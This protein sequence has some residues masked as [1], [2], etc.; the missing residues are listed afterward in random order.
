[1]RVQARQD[2]WLILYAIEASARRL[3]QF[4]PDFYGAA[5]QM[6]QDAHRLR[7]HLE[8]AARG[9]DAVDDLAD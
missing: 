8:Q 6:E 3:W 4:G 2:Q 5:L 1:M 9:C 7:Q